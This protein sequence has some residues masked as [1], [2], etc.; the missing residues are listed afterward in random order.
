[1]RPFK[2]ARIVNSPGSAMRAPLA[3]ASSTMCRNTTGDPCAEISTT[4]SAVYE[5]GFAKYVTTTSSIRPVLSPAMWGRVPSPVRSSAAR[6]LSGSELNPGCP[7]LRA[8][9]ASGGIAVVPAD[10]ASASPFSGSTNSPNSALPG[11]TR[12]F[13]RNM[14][15]AI[16]TASGPASRTTPIPPRPEGVATATMVSSRFTAS[17]VLDKLRRLNPA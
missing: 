4:S 17:I 12:C 2:N 13:S 7:I 9:L 1:M 10:R 16:A 8:A 11:S 3:N 5:C 14:G 6:Q 15:I